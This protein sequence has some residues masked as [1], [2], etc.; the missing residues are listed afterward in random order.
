[1]KWLEVRFPL[2]PRRLCRLLFARDPARRREAWWTHWH[3]G[4]VWLMEIVEF[5]ARTRFARRPRRLREAYSGVWQTAST[6]LPSG[7]RT[8]AP[9]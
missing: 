5:A 3:T 2:R 1:M 6:L 4:L 9:K 8:K 7:S